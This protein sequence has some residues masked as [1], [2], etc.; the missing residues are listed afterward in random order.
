MK[1]YPFLLLLGAADLSRFS[2]AIAEMLVQSTINDL[3]LLPALPRHVWPYGCVKGL[4]ARGGL[5]VNM[6]WT[7]GD[8][9][10]VGLWSSEQISLTTLHYRETTV[11]ANLS[12]GKVYTFNKLLKCVRTYSLPK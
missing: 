2:A 6:C 12:S 8:L 10:E 11:A 4:K 1:Q 7:G 9:D 5:T 3:Y